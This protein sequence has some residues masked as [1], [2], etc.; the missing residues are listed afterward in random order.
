VLVPELAMLVEVD[1]SWDDEVVEVGA[2]LLLDE[3]VV[4]PET[5]CDFPAFNP[6]EP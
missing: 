6:W 2:G 5:G 3:I 4:V 1:W